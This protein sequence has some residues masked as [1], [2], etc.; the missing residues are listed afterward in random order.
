M[1]KP[2]SG[3]RVM[4]FTQVFAGPMCTRILADQ[5]SVTLSEAKGLAP[6]VEPSGF[7]GQVLGGVYPEQRRR[8]QHD[9]AP[10]L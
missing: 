10:T 9:E 7:E 1:T 8:A 4:D 6:R 5:P 3:V 2:L